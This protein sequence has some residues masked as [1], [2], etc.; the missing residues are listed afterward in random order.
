METIFIVPYKTRFEWTRNE[1]GTFNLTHEEW[2]DNETYDKIAENTKL[3]AESLLKRMGINHKVTLNNTEKSIIINYN[4]VTGQML[5]GSIISETA[6]QFLKTERDYL[7]AIAILITVSPIGGIVSKIGTNFSDVLEEVKQKTSK[8]TPEETEQLRF[9]W[10]GKTKRVRDCVEEYL[11][12]IRT[13][14]RVPQHRVR[15][16][17][18]INENNMRKRLKELRDSD[19]IELYRNRAHKPI[20]LK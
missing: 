19:L 5:I 13:G 14:N 20:N 3:T 9:F 6:I 7:N 4:R 12:G 1:D 15:K 11:E 2:M 17:Y 16:K 8:L 18:G 10:M